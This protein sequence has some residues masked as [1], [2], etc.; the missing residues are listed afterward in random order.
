VSTVRQISVSIKRGTGQISEVTDMLG[1][2]GVNIRGFSVCDSRDTCVLHLIVDSPDAARSALESNNVAFS[3]KDVICLM[4][5]DRPGSLAAALATVASAGVRFECV[6]SLI[7]P[8]AVLDVEDPEVAL[9]RLKNQPVHIVDQ[10][11][12]ADI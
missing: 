7:L 1:D 11:E 8:Y 12:I 9:E 6:Y 4:L 2:A 3:E 10:R 5:N